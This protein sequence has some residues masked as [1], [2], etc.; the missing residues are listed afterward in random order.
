MLATEVSLT[1]HAGER[2]GVV[3]PNG[4]GKSTLLAL[5]AGDLAAESGDVDMPRG[6][7][8]ARVLQET[9]PVERAAIDYVLDGDGELR[10]IEAELARAHDAGRGHEQALLHERLEAIDGYGA[11][12]RAAALM[13]GL[14]FAHDEQSAPVASFSGGWR[15]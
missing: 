12:S 2:I 3:G 8:I 13:H 15:M 9:E 6:I 14:G 11:R 5:L 10:R 7:R 4:C 1:L